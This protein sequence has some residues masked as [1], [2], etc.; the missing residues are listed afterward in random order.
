MRTKLVAGLAAALLASGSNVVLAQSNPQGGQGNQ[1]QSFGQNRTGP[2]MNQ[3]DVNRD[4]VPGPLSPRAENQ[5]DNQAQYNQTWPPGSLSA[6][7]GNQ[8]N[9]SQLQGQSRASQ[10]ALLRQELRQAGFRDIRIL[11]AAFLVQ[12]S[13]G[14]GQ[15]VVMVVNP[16]EQN[17]LATSSSSGSNRA[18][19]IVG[20]SEQRQQADS[21]R[22]SEMNSGQSQLSAAIM[23]PGLVSQDQIRSHL[24]SRGFSN[25]SGL[26]QDGNTYT[27][28]ADWYGEQVD[29]RVDGRNGF[30]IEPSHITPS[31]VRTMLN[32]MGWGTVDN[33]Q[34]QGTSYRVQASRNGTP[35]SLWIDA[36]T[37]EV[38]RQTASTSGLSGNQPYQQ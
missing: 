18:F 1:G 29:F 17:S 28:M 24:Q 32:E 19:N 12:A 6:G 10:R 25:I 15:Q 9:S 33:I 30:V 5:P 16:P 14:S 34:Q 27:G 26:T 7:G 11:D 13:T 8:N 2:G 21:T 23:T 22:N 20:P 31:Q 35:Y 36:R 38:N 4:W 37:G 3:P